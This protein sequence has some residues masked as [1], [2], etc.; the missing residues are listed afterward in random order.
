MTI[1]AKIM[2]YTNCPNDNTAFPMLCIM[3]MEFLFNVWK[4]LHLMKPQP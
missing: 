3:W 2:R 4:Q 1:Y